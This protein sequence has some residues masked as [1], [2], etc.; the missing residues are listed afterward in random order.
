MYCDLFKELRTGHR[1]IQNKI[2]LDER[3]IR[4]KKG[5]S[6]DYH[7]EGRRAS[8]SHKR[9]GKAR[10]GDS[11]IIPALRKEKEEDH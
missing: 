1:G 7:R 2:K 6:V 5:Y 8:G 10:C 3:K 11:P 4:S 9:K